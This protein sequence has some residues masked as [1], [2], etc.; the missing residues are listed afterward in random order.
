MP[1]IRCWASST[2]RMRTGPEALMS[3]RSISAAR[4]E[5]FLKILPAQ[6]VGDAAQ[7]HRQVLGVDLAEHPLERRIVEL[8][9]V[10]EGEGQLADLGGQLRRVLVQVVQDQALGAAVDVG[11]QRGQVLDAAG[12]GVVALEDG[13]DPAAQDRLDALDHLGRG[14]LHRGDPHGDLG[15]LLG[16]E[17]RQDLGGG[18]GRQVREDQGDGLGLLFLDEVDELVRVGVLEEVEV[19][20][21]GR[22]RCRRAMISEAFSG[23][24]ALESISSA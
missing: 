14:A 22:R 15:A 5:R 10:V 11:E 7:R 23:P 20:R 6:L 12:H 2:W 17:D 18:Q 1:T 9:Q 4:E 16:L 21:A 3:S 24:S 8:D 13:G 19:P